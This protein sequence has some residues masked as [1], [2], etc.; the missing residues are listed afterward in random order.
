MVNERETRKVKRNK[1]TPELI[2]RERERERKS[3]LKVGFLL[4][5]ANWFVVNS[6]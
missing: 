2:K 6:K 5:A 4:T 1:K 3:E